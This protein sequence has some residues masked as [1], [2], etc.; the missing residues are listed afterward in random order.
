M[1]LPNR[2]TSAQ[3]RRI[4]RE[5]VQGSLETFYGKSET[6]ARKLVRNWWG[7]LKATGAFRSGLFLHAE[8]INTAAGI[9][10]AEA[11]SLTAKNRSAYHQILGK[12]R[13]LVLDQSQQPNRRHAKSGLTD[14]EQRRKGEREEVAYSTAN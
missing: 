5:A 9:A 7:R 14:E 6:E 3:E 11:V 12:S 10:D 2:I 13:A 8:P 1:S 4:Y